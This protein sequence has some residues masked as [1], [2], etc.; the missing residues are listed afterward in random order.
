MA[1]PQYTPTPFDCRSDGKISRWT[2]WIGRL[3]NIFIA[4]NITQDIRQKAMLLMYAGDELNDIVESLPNE[5]LIPAQGQKHFDKLVEAVENHFRPQENIEYQ[6]YIFRKLKQTTSDVEDFFNALKNLAP[7]CRFQNENAEIR[8]QLIAGCSSNKVRERG[9]MD[10]NMNLQDLLNFARTTQATAS[11]IRHMTGSQQDYGSENINF[12]ASHRRPQ[13]QTCWNCGGSWPHRNGQRSCPARDKSCT[14]CGKFDHFHSVCRSKQKSHQQRLRYDRAENVRT[15]ETQGNHQPIH[16][17]GYHE[18]IFNN[19]PL[20]SSDY[21]EHIFACTTLAEENNE[22]DT[23]QAKM[24]ELEEKLNTQISLNTD[25]CKKLEE[26]S[27]KYQ[28]L[29]KRLINKQIPK[30][31]RHTKKTVKATIRYSTTN[32]HAKFSD[33][34]NFTNTETTLDMLTHDNINPILIPNQ[35]QIY[36]TNDS[37]FLF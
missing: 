5:E 2:K 4:H 30:K 21:D 23:L 15:I 34:T 20:H 16:S 22:Q 14:N 37:E 26:Q 17:P 11:H 33:P 36:A 27:N 7:S 9:L 8:S 10:H 31:R 13:N 18:Q 35:K 1:L 24:R 12:T 32:T 29:R 19:Q 25:I 3:K 6:R 28:N